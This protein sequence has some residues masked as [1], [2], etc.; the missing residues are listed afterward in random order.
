MAGLA[1]AGA[2]GAEQVQ[3]VRRCLPR[4][5]APAAR[6]AI[7]RTAARRSARVVHAGP[8]RAPARGSASAGGAGALDAHL[9][10]LL[11]L[12]RLV[13]ADGG[14]SAG[15]LARRYL[16]G[17][18]RRVE[19]A[20]GPTPAGSAPDSRLAWVRMTIRSTSISLDS[21]SVSSARRRP[22]S[23]RSSAELAE[24]LAASEFS[25]EDVVAQ[26]GDAGHLVAQGGQC[27]DVA[28][29]LGDA[30]H[31]VAQTRQR[32]DVPAQRVE[33]VAH[34]VLGLAAELV[35]QLELV[36]AAGGDLALELQLVGAAQLRLA[37]RGVGLV[38]APAAGGE[39]GE[40]ERPG[41]G[42][43]GDAQVL[44]VVGEED[45]ERGGDRQ[46][47]PTGQHESPRAGGARWAARATERSSSALRGM[48]PSVAADGAGMLTAT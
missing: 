12:A 44:R 31:L 18:A 30:G 7:P 9:L 25:G 36:L 26:R 45:G 8:L 1:G 37:G 39:G 28:A 20:P 38:A 6:T 23:A 48:A 3:P 35:L 16:L 33:L 10:E 42:D 40:D 29:Q 34:R 5:L 32:G 43:D 14:P 11:G 47:E 46:R 13:E 21:C 15:Q 2:V 41:H 4:R 17:P 24:L 22:M 19:C 27:G